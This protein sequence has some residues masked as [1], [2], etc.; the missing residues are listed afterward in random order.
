VAGS[1]RNETVDA[2][3]SVDDFVV[4]PVLTP[5]EVVA[6]EMASGLV[7]ARVA[8]LDEATAAAAAEAVPGA[9]GIMEFVPRLARFKASCAATVGGANHAVMLAFRPD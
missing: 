8:E 7:V 6:D 3:W 4:A 1:C 5:V 2:V 9:A